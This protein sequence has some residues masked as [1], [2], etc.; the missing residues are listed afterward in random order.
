VEHYLIYL[1]NPSAHLKSAYLHI[2][3]SGAH[4]SLLPETVTYKTEGIGDAGA[5][6]RPVVGTIAH[7]EFMGHFLFCQGYVQ[8]T[9]AYG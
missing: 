1:F 4:L 9:V 7:P 5:P 8:H 3:T 6:V 2:C